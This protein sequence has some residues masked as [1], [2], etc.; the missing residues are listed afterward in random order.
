MFED[1]DETD[2]F[3]DDSDSLSSV[4]ETTDGDLFEAEEESDREHLVDAIDDEIRN[5]FFL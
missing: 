2:D 3:W 1:E 4:E 5:G